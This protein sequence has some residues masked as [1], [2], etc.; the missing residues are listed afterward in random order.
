[1]HGGVQHVE[2]WVPDLAT[3]ISTWGRLFDRLGFAP[4][5]PHDRL[6]PGLNHLAFHVRSMAALDAIVSDAARHGWRL[7][8]PERHP[9]AGGPDHYA[10]YLEDA[11]GFEVAL[12]AAESLED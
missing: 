9:H 6:R 1:M 2:P 12:V 5:E 10:A 7:L 4:A 11:Y 8:F 3:A